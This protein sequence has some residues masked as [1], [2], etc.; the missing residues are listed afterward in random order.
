M[1]KKT[2]IKKQLHKKILFLEYF[3]ILWNVFEGIISIS[4]GVISG[5][6]SLVA[7]G[8]E[9]SIE[10]FSSS[11]AV[12][13][14]NGA[15]SERRKA[16]L[17]MISVALLIVAVYIAYNTTESFFGGHR[18]K[19]TMIGI[20]VMSLITVIMFVGGKAKRNLGLK[21]KNPVILAESNFTLMDSALSGSILCGLILNFLLG[22]WWTDQLLA[23]VIALNAFKEGIKGVSSKIRIIPF[24]F[25][26]RVNK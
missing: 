20:V 19:P 23:L 10:V 8:L 15:G 3:T 25:S 18:A 1:N 22:W 9:S 14:L 5:S 4:I 24:S 26:G 21:M 7:F 16:A 17:K 13:E 12:W 6:V 2:Q 11:V